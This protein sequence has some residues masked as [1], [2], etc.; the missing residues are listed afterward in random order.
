MTATRLDI[1][2]EQGADYDG[3]FAILDHAGDPVDLT[4]YAAAMQVRLFSVYPTALLTLTSIDGTLLI[5]AV[6]GT[7]TPIIPGSVTAAINPGHYLYDL[8]LVSPAGRTTRPYQ[9]SAYV[10]AEV[11]D[12]PIF[13][14]ASY[15]ALL[16]E[17][18]GYLL[19]ENGGR[20]L[21]EDGV[22]RPGAILLENG[23]YLLLETGGRL[24][25]EDGITI[26][27][28][29]LLEG[30]GYLLNET[31]GKILLEA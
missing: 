23:G 28:A 4:G 26:P 31:G 29:L 12:T 10:S 30:G 6:A 17:S 16:L 18:G 3:S 27:G 21:L 1:T 8:K 5:D 15:G 25:V 13:P 2:I 14:P 22:Y 9:G 20:L 11:T 7:V 19:L 24:L